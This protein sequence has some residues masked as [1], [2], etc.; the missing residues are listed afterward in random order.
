M[1]STTPADTGRARHVY[2]SFI[3]L[4]KKCHRKFSPS[5]IPSYIDYFVSRLNKESPY[6]FA[7]EIK[8]YQCHQPH[9]LFNAKN[10]HLDCTFYLHGNIS[11]G[12]LTQ[13]TV[14]KVKVHYSNNITNISYIKYHCPGE[15]QQN[16][17]ILYKLLF[18]SCEHSNTTLRDVLC[19]FSR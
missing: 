9:K 16:I 10:T 14:Q 18:H 8:L 5:S 7:V 2:T 19:Q 3:W 6:K 17:E 13:K 1:G 15:V 11:R 12:R 4:L